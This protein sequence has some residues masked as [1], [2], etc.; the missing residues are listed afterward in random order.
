MSSDCQEAACCQK[1]GPRLHD[2]IQGPGGG[3]LGLL[4]VAVNTSAYLNSS[5]YKCNKIKFP[6]WNSPISL[7]KFTYSQQLMIIMEANK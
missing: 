6:E 5:T 3:D 1:E 4:C 2:T 7:H